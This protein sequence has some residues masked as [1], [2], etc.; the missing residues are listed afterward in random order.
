MREYEI[1]IDQVSGTQVSGWS[2]QDSKVKNKGAREVASSKDSHGCK[3]QHASN[4]TTTYLMSNA[5]E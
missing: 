1:C 4:K 5:G 3:Q 2:H